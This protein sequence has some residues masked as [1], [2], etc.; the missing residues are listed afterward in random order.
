MKPAPMMTMN[1]PIVVLCALALPA[2]ALAGFTDKT[3]TMLPSSG[4]TLE[5]WWVC[6][7]DYNNDGFVDFTDYN[8]LYKNSGPTAPYATDFEGWTTPDLDVAPWS[9]VGTPGN[10]AVTAGLGTNLSDVVQ[11][12]FGG[13][14]RLNPAEAQQVSQGTLEFDVLFNGPTFGYP[15]LTMFLAD[16]DI[17]L[18]AVWFRVGQEPD[19]GGDGLDLYV[20]T[21][22]LGTGTV[23]LT[24]FVS[25]DV[26]YT[27]RIDFDTAV[28]TYDL[29]VDGVLK[30]DD[31]PIWGAVA[32][33]NR[34]DWHNPVGWFT[35]VDNV[36]LTTEQGTRFTWEG[37]VGD[38][39][40][41]YD[42]DGKL[43]NYRWTSNTPQLYRNQSSAGATSFDNP[44]TMPDLPA[45][46]AT[47]SG[48]SLAACWADF[49][50]DGFLDVFVGGADPTG[51]G[52]ADQYHDVL[53]LNSNA[54][55][56]SSTTVGASAKY[57]RGVTACD[58]DEDGDM[59][60]YVS[61]YDLGTPNRFLR[62]NGSGIF[63]DV[64]ATTHPN[65]RSTSPGFSGSWAAGAAWGDLDND[66]DF[67]LFA[68]NFAHAGQPES[69]FL[70]NKG[71]AFDHTFTDKGQSGVA[72]VESY[73]SPALAD[74]DN[75]GDLDLFFTAVYAG[76][77][78]RLYRND[79]SGTN[80][81]FTNVTAAEGLGSVGQT[82]QGAWADVE[83]DGDLDLVTHQRIFINNASENGNHWLRVRLK[84]D[85]ANVNRAAIGAQ[86]RIDL[87]GG[88]VLTRQVEAGTGQ[89]NQNE[90]TLHFGLGGHTDPVE[91]DITWPN[92]TT[93]TVSNLAVDQTVVVSYNDVWLTFVGRNANTEV[94]IRWESVAGFNY[95]V[96][97]SPDPMSGVFTPLA[98]GLPATPM[99]NT[100]TDT[101]SGIE[102]AV[103]RVEE[104]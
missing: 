46:A 66:G 24:D 9:R 98:T 27:F 48:T 55:S 61:I 39:W 56:F 58:W 88:T 41:D 90:P 101:V 67:D 10:V 86:V 23:R 40:G 38:V 14:A 82:A 100:Y 94:I 73:I 99:V 8:R 69:R 29:L 20:F 50:G 74:Y 103:Y 32:E 54:T 83:N 89:G 13:F 59:D 76:Q 33:I 93:K 47:S 25:K 5:G 62:N 84:G 70:E 87:G 63:A 49:N 22:G 57:T 64:A 72:W 16:D 18:Q 45:G 79:S 31:E 44:I 2:V 21:A 53:L 11:V 3:A 28:G 102:N 78:P 51:P 75:D 26:W 7:A 12:G 6:W 97:R 36:R 95:T 1:N 60:I 104:E 43:D 96:S 80:W 92:G 52:G 19:A 37:Y 81:V 91:L 4:V 42:N 65:A 17:P 71:S 85:G 35:Q 34:I 68:G 77:F 15:V 30:L